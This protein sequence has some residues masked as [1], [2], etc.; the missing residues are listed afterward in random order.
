M[1]GKPMHFLPRTGKLTACGVI[2]QDPDFGSYD[3]RYVDC[4]RCQKTKAWKVYIGKSKPKKAY[5]LD[6]LLNEIKKWKPVHQLHPMERE[7][8]FRILGA[9]AYEQLSNNNKE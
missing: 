6:A 3:G 7:Q 9:L 4:L 1:I 8:F 5:A 2:I